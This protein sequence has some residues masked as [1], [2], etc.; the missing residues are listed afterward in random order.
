MISSIDA[1][2]LRVFAHWLTPTGAPRRYDT[3]FFVA[4]APDGQ[5][6]A[7]DDSE[8]VASE[9]VRPADA[10]A[11]NERG[12]IELILP[13]LRSLQA[14]AR[15]AS[16]AALFARARP[17]AASTRTAGC[18]SSPR[19]G[20]RVVLPERRRRVAR[21]RGRFHFLTSACATSSASSPAEACVEPAVNDEQPQPSRL[22]PGVPS[23]LSPLVRRVLAPNPG[24]MTGPGTNTYLVG[25]DEVAVIDPGPADD[26]HVDAIVG[27]SM[28]DRVRWVLLTHTHPD[29]WPA[30][31]TIRKE[32]GALV[33]GF[34]KAPKADEFDLKLDLVLD[35]RRDDRRH[36]VPA[37]SDA[38]ARPRAEPPV[39]LPRGGA[40][41]CSPATTCSTARRPSSTR[42]AA[43]T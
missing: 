27:A 8:L 23:A 14:L 13:T 22:I 4:R 31:E 41:R 3:W 16:V 2:D 32:T 24:L 43:A 10:L 11:R 35:R 18:A 28:R 15:F 7:H 33:A 40:A 19:L 29:H 1:T 5:D 42:S 38:H 12:E 36:R 6:G 25:I 17:G 21:A 20:E 39:L 26:K 9:W 34:G 37:R 30:A